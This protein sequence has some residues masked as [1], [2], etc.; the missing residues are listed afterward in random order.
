MN[1]SKVAG[2][3]VSTQKSVAFLYANN[4][5]SEKEIT[6]AISSTIALKNKI[7]R[8]KLNQGGESLVLWKLQSIAERNYRWHN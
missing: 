3:K 5:Q 2:H 6:K 7:L 8:N 4:E 1:S